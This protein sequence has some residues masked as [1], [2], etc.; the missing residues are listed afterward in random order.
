MF[1]VTGN[2]TGIKK[3]KQIK[4]KKVKAISFIYFVKFSGTTLILLRVLI[5]KIFIIIADGQGG[6]TSYYLHNG[7]IL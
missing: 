7:Y 5:K 1:S 2:S 3:L 6:G 4:F